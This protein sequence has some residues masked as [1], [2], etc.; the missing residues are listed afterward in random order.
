MDA[1][2]TL[3]KHGRLIVI[4]GVNGV[5]KTTQ[6]RLAKLKLAKMGFTVTTFKFPDEASTIGDL[7]NRVM[8]MKQTLSDEVLLTLFAANRLEHKQQIEEALLAGHLV[9]CDRYSESEYAYGSALGLPNDWLLNLESRMP[10]ADLVLLLDLEPTI[11]RQRVVMAGRSD[12]FETDEKILEAARAEYIALY[13]N[14]PNPHQK[15]TRIDA[16]QP[17]DVVLD[18]VIRQISILTA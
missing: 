14:P 1:T 8:L 12:Q 10:V 18:E 3:S 16:S 4:E 2:N 13:Q 15:W 7:I 17:I 5:G 6:V 11:A 9:L